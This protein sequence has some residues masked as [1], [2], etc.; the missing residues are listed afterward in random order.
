MTNGGPVWT[1]PE[2]LFGMKY[3]IPSIQELLVKA[4]ST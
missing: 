4:D 1:V 3:L 2:L